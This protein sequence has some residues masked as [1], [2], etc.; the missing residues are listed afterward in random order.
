MSVTQ[1]LS[2]PFKPATEN[3]LRSIKQRQLV[4]HW[5]SKCGDRPLPL[6]SQAHLTDFPSMRDDLSVLRVKQENGALRLQII[7]HGSGPGL[8]YNSQCAGKHID[9]VVPPDAVAATHEVYAKCIGTQRP[10]YTIATTK[11]RFAKP[12]AYERLLMPFT[13]G[14]T[15]VEI[16]LASLEAISVE[17]AFERS[18]LLGAANVNPVAGV[19]AII[20]A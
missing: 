18:N 2:S 6:W 5:A 8:L 11:D 16:I 13:L 7:E 1:S 9:E 20:M 19:R 3:V 4:K 17:G 15:E 12:V 10:V 14:G